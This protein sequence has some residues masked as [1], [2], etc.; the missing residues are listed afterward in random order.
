MLPLSQE[1]S[2]TGAISG[3][4][5]SCGYRITAMLLPHRFPRF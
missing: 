2:F 3:F 4:G 5:S 1:D